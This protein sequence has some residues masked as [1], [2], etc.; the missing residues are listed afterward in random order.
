[1]A[2]YACKCGGT[3]RRVGWQEMYAR[4]GRRTSA[5]QVSVEV[6]RETGN[7]AVGWGDSGLLHM[8]A[9]RLGMPED[10]PATE[11]KVLDRI[12]RSHSGL[13]VKRY[14]SYPERGLSRLREYCLPEVAAP[15]P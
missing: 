3:L 11:R 2:D 1:M 9:K 12:E 10:G 14:K 4:S 15:P 8:I 13:L 6:L 5:A 7:P